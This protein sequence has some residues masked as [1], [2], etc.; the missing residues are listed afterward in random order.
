[1]CVCI[2]KGDFSKL[3]GIDFEKQYLQDAYD[4]VTTAEAWD[5]MASPSNPGKDGFMLSSDPE[6]AK[7]KG[8]MK[9]LMDH[10]GGSFGCTMRVIEMIAKKG[11][12]A[13][14]DSVLFPPTC[15]CR[16]AKGL[17]GWCGVAGGG[18]PGCEH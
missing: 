4:A 9:R 15:R 16:R 1:M 12:D 18:V 6:V 3:P 7:I 8:Y 5:W 10:S 17:T 13:Y 2:P 11:W 14:V